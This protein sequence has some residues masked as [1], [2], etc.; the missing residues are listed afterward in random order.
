[1]SGNDF[2]SW[3]NRSDDELALA[4]ARGIR[5]ADPD[6]L[7]TVELDYEGQRSAS[8]DD[9]RWRPLIAL[10]A[11]YTYTPTYAQVLEEYRRSDHMPVFMV[12]ANYDGEFAYRGP[13]TL[14]RQE[15]WA[16]LS[17]DG[18]PTV[19]ESPHLAVPQGLEDAPEHGRFAADDDT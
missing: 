15:Y 11:A 17:G 19:W 9:A 16:M 7:Q 13:R 10:D 3:Q 2:Q 14:R 5:S 4:V 18:R 6:H 8:L 12:E 1:M